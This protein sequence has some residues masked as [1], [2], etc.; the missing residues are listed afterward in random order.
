MDLN[1]VMERI[2]G[3]HFMMIGQFGWEKIDLS[4]TLKHSAAMPGV[5][6]TETTPTRGGGA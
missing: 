2:F 3:E 4:K 5:K 1:L 6:W